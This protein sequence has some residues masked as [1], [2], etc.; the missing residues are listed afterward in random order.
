[1]YER[2]VDRRAV[3]TVVVVVVVAKVIAGYRVNVRRRCAALA[4]R[5]VLFAFWI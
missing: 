4:R 3:T 5:V 1:M 2:T